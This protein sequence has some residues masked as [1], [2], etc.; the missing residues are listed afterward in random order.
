MRRQ[1]F[2]IYRKGKEAELPLLYEKKVDFDDV[3]E[4]DSEYFTSDSQEG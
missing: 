1:C 3:G 4:S 2:R